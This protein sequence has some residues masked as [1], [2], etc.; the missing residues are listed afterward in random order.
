[1]L[2]TCHRAGVSAVSLNIDRRTN[3]VVVFV[4]EFATIILDVALAAPPMATNDGREND[5]AAKFSAI[6]P[7]TP[8]PSCAN[9]L[10]VVP[11]WFAF[12]LPVPAIVITVPLLLKNPVP[13]PAHDDGRHWAPY[14]HWVVPLVA[15]FEKAPAL[16]IVA[17]VTLLVPAPP[18]R[19]YTPLVPPVTATFVYEELVLPAVIVVRSVTP[20][21][22]R[23]GPMAT[24]ALRSLR[25]C[26]IVPAV[27]HV[28]VEHE[29]PDDTI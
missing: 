20:S 27:P 22:A 26:R 11:S 3:V 21:G 25:V 4:T 1:M 13:M 9:T 24:G 7:P 12:A 23:Q 5:D 19:T 18:A 17:A 29:G 8:T 15:V 6:D 10:V 16:A 2:L 14:K 28:V